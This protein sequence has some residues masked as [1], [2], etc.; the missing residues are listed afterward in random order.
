MPTFRK[1]SLIWKCLFSEI[2]KWNS[3]VVT[4]S[5]VPRHFFN[6]VR[7]IL[8]NPFIYWCMDTISNVMMLICKKKMHFIVVFQWFYG[9]FQ[10][11]FWQ[12]AHT[13]VLIRPLK[14]NSTNQSDFHNFPHDHY[15][16]PRNLADATWWYQLPWH[17]KIQAWR[18]CFDCRLVWQLNSR[19]FLLLDCLLTKEDE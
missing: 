10:S 16:F 13:D 6:I 4:D 3:N 2:W 9:C 19:Y 1:V 14:L 11:I 12:Y 18:I 7:A 15:R 17:K 8:L 5:V